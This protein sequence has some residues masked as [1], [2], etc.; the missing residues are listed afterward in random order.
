[1]SL[2]KEDQ[3]LLL[4]ELFNMVGYHIASFSEVPQINFVD[5]KPKS[6]DPC[7][8]VEYDEYNRT[9]T[10]HTGRFGMSGE[11]IM[12]KLRMGFKCEVTIDGV[13]KE[14]EYAF[15][16]SIPNVADDNR[17]TQT[18]ALGG[19]FIFNGD[20]DLS[21]DRKS[22][23]YEEKGRDNAIY[24]TPRTNDHSGGQFETE[25]KLF[26]DKVPIK[27]KGIDNLAI[28]YGGQTP[29]T[30]NTNVP[31]MLDQD[32][33]LCQDILA[34]DED[35][36]SGFQMAMGKNPDNGQQRPI[37]ANDV[38]QLFE[39]LGKLHSPRSVKER[40]TNRLARRPRLGGGN[41]NNVLNNPNPNNFNNMNNFANNNFA[42]GAN[43][44]F[45]G[46]LN[47]NNNAFPN[48]N[49]NGFN[50]NNNMGMGGNNHMLF[51]NNNNNMFP[52][53]NN[54]M[55]MGV[56]MNQ[57]N[58]NNNIGMYNNN[59]VMNPFMNNN[60]NNANNNMNN[61]NMYNNQNAAQMPFNNGFMNL[62]N[63]NALNNQ[64][65]YNAVGFG[66]N[67]NNNNGH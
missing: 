14:L 29:Q 26:E 46:L 63:N 45:G 31:N 5:D 21:P 41:Q 39:S 3:E 9:L 18:S 54:N 56:G 6:N 8:H 59:N 10:I 43:N 38:P 7:K 15:S 50:F 49:N 12:N 61:N 60:V 2:A 13:A 17:V 66:Y 20:Y 55:G 33:W 52:L 67:G 47:N 62:N 44:N 28:K 37:Q 23:F 30:N 27:P 53:N 48:V 35:V 16:D 58:M 40:V 34:Y 36:E 51:N 57:N 24:N 19:Y 1:M 11:D 64:G 22:R 25:K 65:L 42:W 4:Q 32:E